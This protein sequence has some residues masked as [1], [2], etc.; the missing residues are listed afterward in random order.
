VVFDPGACRRRDRRLKRPANPLLIELDQTVNADERDIPKNDRTPRR[1]NIARAFC[2]RRLL[3]RRCKQPDISSLCRRG[4]VMVGTT[5]AAGFCLSQVTGSNRA[6]MRRW[7]ATGADRGGPKGRNY[8]TATHTSR[9]AADYGGPANASIS[10]KDVEE[11]GTE[12]GASHTRDPSVAGRNSRRNSASQ[13]IPSNGS[14]PTV[15]ARVASAARGSGPEYRNQSTCRDD[16]L[17]K[18]AQQGQ[19]NC[20]T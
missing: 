12:F 18:A 14:E 20:Q 16:E 1:S 17:P 9:G 15:E 2:G 3:S 4:P 13:T 19:R 6:K 10:E 7:P 5:S 11:P 8:Q